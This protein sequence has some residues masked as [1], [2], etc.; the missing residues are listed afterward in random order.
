MIRFW[1]LEVGRSSER[2][3]IA[4]KVRIISDMSCNMEQFI[5]ILKILL[6]S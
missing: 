5:S 2:E 6:Y 4:T 1:V 3:N